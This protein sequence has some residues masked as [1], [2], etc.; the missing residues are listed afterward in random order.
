MELG[1][2]VNPSMLADNKHD[3]SCY[4]CNAKEEPKEVEN[5]LVDDHDEDAHLTFKNDA[6]KLGKAIGGDQGKKRITLEGMKKDGQELDVSVAAHHL[7]PGNASL[8]ESQLF[9]SNKYLWK[10]K[11]VKGNIG[12]NVNDAPNGVWL[13]G[14]Y[15]ARPWGAGGLEFQST[16]G[17][18]PQTY[19]FAAIE[20]WG[21]QFHDAHESYSTFVMQGL[22]KIFQKL[23][24]NED[25]WCPE[26]KKKDEPPD[27]RK[28]MYVLVSRLNTVSSRM[29]QML[30]APSTNWKKNIYTS[31]FSLAYMAVKKTHLHLVT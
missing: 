13:P 20:A 8:K 29:R 16:F 25:V 4:F 28:P 1:E 5:D 31:R 9:Q 15:A 22:N 21:A 10:D 26:A 24:K 30:V 14:N 7:I 17:P 3:D 12:Y 27:K 6:G 2:D 11:K 23:E 19:A 18:S